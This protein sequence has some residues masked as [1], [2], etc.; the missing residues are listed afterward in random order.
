VEGTYDG[1]KDGIGD[2]ALVNP[3]LIDGRLSG[4]LIGLLD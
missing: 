4:I 1:V 3:I 2:G